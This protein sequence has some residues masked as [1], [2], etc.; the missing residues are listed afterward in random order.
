MARRRKKMALYEVINRTSSKSNYGKKLGPLHPPAAEQNSSDSADKMPAAAWPKKPRNLQFFAGRLEFSVPYPLAIAAV[1]GLILLLLAAFRLGQITLL[2]SQ[3]SSIKAEKLTNVAK[4]PA[5][6]AVAG[7]VKTAPVRTRIAASA[8]QQGD[9]RI[10]IQT[11]QLRSH[12][13][14]AK[15]YFAKFGIETQITKLGIWHYLVTK[16]KFV[17]PEKPGTNGYLIKQKIVD[18]GAR[19][20]APDG[21][22]SFGKKPFHDAYGM[23]FND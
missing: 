13:E 7:P 22:E 6:P 15:N 5:A 19:Y 10:V 9:N 21:F 2:T 12:L 17:N 1:L 20:K 11:Y 18:L 23:K 8:A 16:E 14:P 4:T 3:K